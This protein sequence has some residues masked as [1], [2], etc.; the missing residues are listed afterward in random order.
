MA[1]SRSSSGEGWTASAQVFSG[2]PDPAWPV[3][4]AV[5]EELVSLWE[6]MTPWS[7]PPPE[8]PQLGYRGAS[9]ADGRRRWVAY[10]GRVTLTDE[11]SGT[12]R[13]DEGRAFERRLVETAP[14]GLLPEW[15]LDEIG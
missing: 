14:P 3:P 11:A 5:A 8:P 10:R 6:A 2:R 15:A 4:R 12:S 13:R 9:L 1:T 7:G